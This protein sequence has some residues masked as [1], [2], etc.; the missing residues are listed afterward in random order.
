VHDDDVHRRIR[1]EFQ[2]MP[3]LTLTLTQASRLFDLE[4]TR[5][6]RVLGQLVEGGALTTDGRAF[7]SVGVGRRYA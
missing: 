1:A 2:E 7:A 4:P 3:G 6:A 5:C